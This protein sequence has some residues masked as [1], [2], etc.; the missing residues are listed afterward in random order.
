MCAKVF[1]WNFQNL[2]VRHYP[3]DFKLYNKC[4]SIHLK[5]ENILK[6]HF[7]RLIL[8]LQWRFLPSAWPVMHTCKKI[9]VCFL[10]CE[11]GTKHVSYTF[12][13]AYMCIS[14]TLQFSK[15]MG[16]IVRLSEWQRRYWV[17]CC[18][19][20]NEL[21]LATANYLSSTVI[22]KCCFK[23]TASQWNRYNRSKPLN[24]RTV[25]PT[26]S[27]YILELIEMLRAL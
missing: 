11:E 20:D 27:S 18:C 13:S 2:S 15:N 25:N 8:T 23:G 9:V 26:S 19:G 7:Y 12:R 1:F 16:A 21:S 3:S 14:P 17:I 10:F 24:K 6:L 5:R 22:L 4:K